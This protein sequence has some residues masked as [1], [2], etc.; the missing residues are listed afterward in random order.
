M[1]GVS[2]PLPDEAFVA[3]LVG[4]DGMTHRR[5]RLLLGRRSPAEAWAVAT[6]AASAPPAVADL[7]RSDPTLAGRW[8]RSA[9]SRSVECVWD[10][11]AQGGI[12]VVLPSAIDFPAQLVDDPTC[13]A[14][15][16]VR[17]DLG[18]LDGRRVAI[19]GTRNATQRG[20]ETAAWFGHDL[21]TAGVAVVSGL[22]KGVDGAAHRGC[23]A[24][25]GRPVG[26]V[27]NGLD[28]PYPRQH[29]P[30]W[31]EVAG[32]GVLISEWPPGTRP[33]AFR[34]PLRNRLIAALAEIVVVIESRE[35]GG[36]L[37][38]AREAAER[39]VPVFA[40]PGALDSPASVGTNQL[41]RDGVAPATE[42]SDV[43]VALGLD[44]RRSGR[45][46]VDH[47]RPPDA[48][49]RRVVDLA[50]TDPLTVDATA[51]RLHVDVVDAAM[52]LARLERDGWLV[53][54]GGWFEL[55][56][57]WAALA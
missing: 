39:G 23:L 10:A 32:R 51:T 40:V 38:T 24:A 3:A 1:G 30:L 18:V 28:D 21:A 25:D 17:G 8:S 53:E 13:P 43:L 35:R 20:R 34:F 50:R 46:R 22:A 56:G 49:G 44:T 37:S 9:A 41:L 29:G 14:A 45:R 42:P 16:F 5:S 54:A 26:I 19:V 15:L 47:R 4:L 12:R 57:D 33:D 31:G 27:G 7:F 11:C 36:S 48:L 2:A 55:A 6:G 52:A